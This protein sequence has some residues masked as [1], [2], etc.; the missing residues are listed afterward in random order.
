MIIKNMGEF[1]AALDDGKQMQISLNDV[2]RDRDFDR[3]EIR[4]LRKFIKERRIRIKPKVTYFRLWVTRDQDGEIK[5]YDLHWAESP[6]CPPEKEEH[7]TGWTHAFD[8][9]LGSEDGK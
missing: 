2:W 3:H 1:G 9:T 8:Y 4:I 6:F 7:D 5:D